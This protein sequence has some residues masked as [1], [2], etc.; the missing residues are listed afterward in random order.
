[1]VNKEK[2][3]TGYLLGINILHVVVC[4]AVMLL[5]KYGLFG[6]SYVRYIAFGI[7]LFIW[8]LFAVITALG[9]K[10]PKV[11]YAFAYSILAILPI[12]LIVVF[13]F[14]ISMFEGL[15]WLKFFFVG[16]TV[17][18]YFRPFVSLSS[19]LSMSAYLFYSV[20]IL[21]LF[22]VGLLGCIVG[23]NMDQKKDRSKKQKKNEKIKTAQ[24]NSAKPSKANLEKMS[25]DAKLIE[26]ESAQD[27]KERK[28]KASKKAEVLGDNISAE[29]DADL[30]K[31]IERL[32]R[33]LE[34]MKKKDAS[35]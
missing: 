18:F 20:C 9:T 13:C 4:F 30:Q 16:S 25:E 21:L 29:T 22:I 19:V 31:E 33:K 35:N 28:E 32:Q 24:K 1:M 27:K 17:N 12:L 10:M 2:N 8:F 15:G 23:I 7:T 26:D 6:A 34:E 14:G 11:K 3:L 5:R